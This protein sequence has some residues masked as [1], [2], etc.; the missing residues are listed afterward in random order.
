MPDL[1]REGGF[2]RCSLHRF[3]VNKSELWRGMNRSREKVKGILV[4]DKKLKTLSQTWEKL[5]NSG[6]LLKRVI[7]RPVSLGSRSK[8]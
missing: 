1:W 6:P 3:K 5:H 7:W 8:E 4:K 2:Q